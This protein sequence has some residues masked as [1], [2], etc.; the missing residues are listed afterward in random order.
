MFQEVV[1]GKDQQILIYAAYFNRDHQPV[2]SFSGRKIRQFPPGF[3]VTVMAEG[4]DDSEFR[5]ICAG[6]LT[7]LGFHGLCDVE[8]KSDAETNELKIME[9]NP[10]A[11]RWYGVV[12]SCGLNLPYLAY[13]DLIGNKVPTGLTQKKGKRWVHFFR[14]FLS[15]VFYF[16]KKEL[17]VKDWLN[18]LK[19][20]KKWAIYSPGDLLPFFAS[21]LG[22]SYRVTKSLKQAVL[23][24]FRE[25]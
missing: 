17:S 11:G 15:S 16:Q 18:S 19:G 1:R 12:E 2:A 14:D 8:F 6:F 21:F 20:P 7:A 3:G 4:R 10:R 25:N 23:A 24:R 13:L 9:I 22:L 5:N